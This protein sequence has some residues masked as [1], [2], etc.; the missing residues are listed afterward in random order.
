MDAGQGRPRSPACPRPRCSTVAKTMAKNRPGFII[1]AMGQTQ[2]TNGN[3]IV[4][5]SSILQLALGNVGAPAAAATSTAATTT[6]RARP[7]S[8]RTPTRCR[9]TTRSPCPARGR[10]GRAVWSV[11]LE[12]M[13][14]QYASEA[15]MEKP[16]MT[17]SR[18]IDG[19]LEKNEAID[20]DPNL[21]AI[22]FWGHAPNSQTRGSE[23]LEAMKKLDL[24][25]VHRSVSVGDR[26][27]VRDGAQGRRLPAAGRDAVRD[28]TGSVTASNRSL[29]WREKVIEPLFESRTDHMIMYQLAQKFGFADQFVG[30]KDG[31]QRSS[32]SRAR[33]AWTSRRWKTR[34][35]EI[36]RGTWTIGYT[37]Q[38][39]ERL[40]AHMQQH[41]RVRRE[42]AARKG[43]KDAKTGYDLTATTSAC[44]GRATARRRSSIPGSPNLYDTSQHV[45]DGGG[46]FRAQF[47]RR[48]GRRQPAGRGRLALRRAPTSRPAIREFDHV[49]LKK[50]GWWDELTDDEKKAAEGKN[51]KTDLSGGIQRVAMKHG[52]H[53]FGNAKA[54]A[55]VW[56]FPDADAA[57]P[58]AAVSARARTWSRS[59]RRTT[60]RRRS[61]ACRRCSSRCSRRRSRTR[62]TRSSR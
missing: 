33:A 28:A 19:V 58:R 9:A 41:A 3:A 5:A 46:C 38:S 7:T 8:A 23:M 62:C 45:M 13:K 24:M 37:G 14:K 2:H 35:D 40:Q 17:V 52:C 54:R 20:Q 22:V 27:D 53:P 50:L 15:M 57:A 31:K 11:D 44:R 6:C 26:G 43:G 48:A 25:V 49:L 61:G 39:P 18:W 10:T 51:W 42:D 47:R 4:R 29:Q 56:N 55:V 34:C 1:W 36:N 59:T 12:W 60:T 21:R 30:K 16:G 32:W